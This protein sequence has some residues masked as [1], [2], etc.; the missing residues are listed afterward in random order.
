VCFHPG[1]ATD[2]DRETGIARVAAAMAF[3]LEQVP[4]ST[5]LWVE[6][7]AGAG[8]TLGKTA[9]EVGAI[10]DLVPGRHRSRTGYGLD[11]CHLFVA[12]HDIAESAAAFRRIIDDFERAAGTPPA[13]FHLNDSTGALGS[14]FDR[15]KLIG[16][17]TIGVEPFRWLLADERSRG[18]PLILET[19]QQNPAVARDDLSPDPW[20]VRMMEL[21]SSLA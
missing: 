12:G 16:E 6:N 19:P 7:T 4:G 1:A 15:H 3:A 11:T 10:L 14:N 13:F 2:G 17:G 5:R 9:G 18:V 8:A 21:L 20:D